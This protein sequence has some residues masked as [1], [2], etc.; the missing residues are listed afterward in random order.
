MKTIRLYCITMVL[1]IA[2]SSC[3]TINIISNKQAGYTAQPHKIYMVISCSSEGKEFCSGLVANLKQSLAQKQV[4]TEEYLRD[5]LALESEADINKKVADYNPDAVLIIKQTI[6]GSKMGT[7]ELTL[8]DS[9][10]KKNVW[11]SQLDISTDN[12][13]ELDGP[14]TISNSAKIVLNKLIED[15]IVP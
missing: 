3:A 5:A 12:Y 10:L 8:F 2:F 4:K 14:A 11:K 13:S 15:K 9:Q 6:T 7:F 1:A